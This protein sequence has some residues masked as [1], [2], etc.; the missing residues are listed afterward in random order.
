MQQ[1]SYALWFLLGSGVGHPPAGRSA[2]QVD[3][4]LLGGGVGAQLGHRFLFD[5]PHPFAG[6][7]EGLADLLQGLLRLAG[8]AKAHLEHLGFAGG[9]RRGEERGHI[10]A[11]AAGLGGGQRLLQVPGAIFEHIAQGALAV[12]PQGSLQGDRVLYRR[13]GRL[14]FLGR[15][16]I[17][18]GGPLGVVGGGQFAGGRGM[19][20]VVV[21]GDG[22]LG[23]AGGEFEDVRGQ[24][25]GPPGV[26]DRPQDGLA[27][28]P[29][30]LC[31]LRSL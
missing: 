12:L 28:P 14:H 10:G 11:A 7:A 20:Q 1:G 9:Q 29:D 22:D 30:G 6:E 8:Q 25:D 23:Q 4:Q 2:G 17:R 18:A 3:A 21:A 31:I 19:A 27:N 5:L 24:A 13:Q 26:L 15:D 16:P